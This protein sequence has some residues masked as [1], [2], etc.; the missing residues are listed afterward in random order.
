VQTLES[1]V[2][3]ATTSATAR[4]HRAPGLPPRLLAAIARSYAV[5]ADFALVSEPGP[6]D[7]SSARV[8]L[9]ST[10]D[11]W[12]IRWGPGSR[13]E[14]HDHGSSAGA[15]YVVEG[16]LEE[17]LL[18][19]VRAG[20]P[21]RRVLRERDDRPMA[22][23]HIHAVANASDTVA[24]SI[25]VYSPPLETMHHFE[26]ATDAEL[27]MTRRELVDARPLTFE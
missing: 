18:N 21:L 1:A 8:R 15:L 5:R 20:R 3:A 14:L 16:E 25:H 12:L 4:A 27:R 7:R 23:S 2:P 9:L 24:A 19:P 6:G 22:R 13:T 26:I 10:H 17:Q 11:I